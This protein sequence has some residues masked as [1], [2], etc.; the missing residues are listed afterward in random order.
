[1]QKE[2]EYLSKLAVVAG[3]SSDAERFD[4][5]AKELPVRIQKYFW[6]DEKH[7]YFDYNFENKKLIEVFGPEAWTALW[8]KPASKEQAKSIVFIMMDSTRFNTKVPLPTLDAA[9]PNF[10]PLK[11]YWRG[12]VWLDQFYFGIKGLENYGYRKESNLLRNKLFQNGEGI[13]TGSAIHENYHPK[14]GK[15]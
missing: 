11:G 10:N 5:E 12:P 7:F 3:N 15:N 2:K 9:N 14:T 1:M 8:T 4:N 6:S 13:L